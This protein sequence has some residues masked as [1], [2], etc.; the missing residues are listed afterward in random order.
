MF[1]N[2]DFNEIIYMLLTYNIEFYVVCV[3]LY[4]FWVLLRIKFVKNIGYEIPVVSLIKVSFNLGACVV[5]YQL[6]CL[7]YSAD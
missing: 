3:L 5:F 7:M 1:R 4:G 2:I 6:V